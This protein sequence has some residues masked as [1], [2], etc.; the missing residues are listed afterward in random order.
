MCVC[1]C[2]CVVGGHR[3]LLQLEGGLCGMGVTPFIDLR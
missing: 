2:V 3:A 1:V